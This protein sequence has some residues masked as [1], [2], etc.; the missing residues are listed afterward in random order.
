M[1]FVLSIDGGGIRGIVPALV[2]AELEKRLE[3]PVAGLF[4]LLC[5]TSTGGILA[6][7]LVKD[8]GNGL[9][10]YSAADLVKIYQ[11][12]GREIFQ[13]SF[14]RGVSSVGSMLDEKYSAKGLEKVLEE[15][16]ENEPMGSALTNVMVTAY[17]IQNREP[18]FMKSW[19][20]KFRSLEMRFAGRATSAAPTYFEPALTPIGGAVRALIDG[21]VFVNNPAVSAYVEAL[22]LYPGEDIFV[23]SIGTG[24]LIRPISFNEAKDWGKAGWML[25]VLDCMFDGVSDAADYQLT[26]L[27]GDKYIRLQT[28]LSLAFDDMDNASAGNIAL[29]TQEAK[30]LLATNK[31]KLLRIVELFGKR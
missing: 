20:D 17:D 31:Q 1:K 25:P 15:Y 8:A 7:G 18:V 3:K 12:R 10:Q 23:L 19:H 4:D 14:W 6:L 13:R 16:F 9:P 5:G 2:L 11:D 21:G 26:Q 28:D 29:L 22:R 27:L 30:K 24:E